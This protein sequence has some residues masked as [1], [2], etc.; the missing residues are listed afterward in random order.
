MRIMNPYIQRRQIHLKTEHQLQLAKKMLG[1]T[2]KWD[3]KISSPWHEGFIA[4]CTVGTLLFIRR[5]Q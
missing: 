2:V 1:F 3:A 4:S 5:K